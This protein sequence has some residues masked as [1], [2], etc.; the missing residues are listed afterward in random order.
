M[1]LLVDSTISENCTPI[2]AIAAKDLHAYLTST[3]EHTRAWIAATG[4]V[5]KQHTH[6]LVPNINGGMAKVLLGVSGADDI[7]AYSHLP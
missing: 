5:A 7:Y 4:F 1:S 6:T 2:V 3:S